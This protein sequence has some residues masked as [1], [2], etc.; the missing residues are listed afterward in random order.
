MTRCPVYG[1]VREKVE[2][3]V[4]NFVIL[5]FETLSRL[6]IKFLFKCYRHAYVTTCRPHYVTIST[7]KNNGE[8]LQPFTAFNITRILRR[9]FLISGIRPYKCELCEKAFTQR[10]SLE[11]H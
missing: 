8:N 5:L 10:C 9:F 6:W 3:F 7:C 1:V 2:Y 11:S 4:A